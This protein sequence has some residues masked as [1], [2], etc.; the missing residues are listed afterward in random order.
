VFVLRRLWREKSFETDIKTQLSYLFYFPVLVIVVS[1]ERVRFCLGISHPRTS[2]TRYS[3]Q[4]LEGKRPYTVI[5]CKCC[6][7]F[8]NYPSV[9]YLLQWSPKWES[10]K[11]LPQVSIFNLLTVWEKETENICCIRQVFASLHTEKYAD[12]E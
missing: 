7:I 1:W 11:L 9:N 8:F 6:E 12:C 4:L 10:N 2:S 5:K 3:V